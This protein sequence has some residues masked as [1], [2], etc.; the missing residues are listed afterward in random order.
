MPHL[1]SSTFWC[2][3]VL[4]IEEPLDRLNMIRRRNFSSLM[5]SN[6]KPLLLL[7]VTIAVCILQVKTAHLNSKY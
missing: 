5:S 4:F 7:R 2:L 6:Y 3:S 1:K